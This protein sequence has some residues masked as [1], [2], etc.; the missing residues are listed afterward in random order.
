MKEF[1]I[2]YISFGESYV[3]CTVA[4]LKSKIKNA[5]KT[6]AIVLTNRKKDLDSKLCRQNGIEVRHINIPAERVREVKTQA[7]RY[8]PWP[9]TLL[10]DAD[11]WIN[12]ELSNQFKM[13]DFTP[14]ALTHAFHHASIGTA[15]HIGN[16]DRELTLKAVGGLKYMPHYASGILFYRRDDKDVRRFFDTWYS[17]W[18]KLKGKDQGALLRAVVASQVFPLVLA[19]RHWITPE[20]G[21]GFISHS[22]GPKLQDMPRKDRRSPRKFKYLP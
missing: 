12:K 2:Q 1:G 21:K 4:A 14:L 6:P 20:Q 16:A 17:E 8:S 19:R 11:A 13:L 9:Y 22:F 18:L 5:P 15:A 7:Y 3:D 10:L